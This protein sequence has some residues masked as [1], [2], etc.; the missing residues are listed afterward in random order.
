VCPQ[1][2]AEPGDLRQPA[3]HQGGL[4]VVA[5]T[6]AVGN[7][8]AQ[9]DNVFQGPAQ[10]HPDQVGVGVNPEVIA[11]EEV[12]D[13][14]GRIHV[15]GRGNNRRGHVQTHLLG[16]A[17][18]GEDRVATGEIVSGFAGKN[19]GQAAHGLFFNPLGGVD[20]LHFFVQIRQRRT[21]R[22]AKSMGRHPEQNGLR[23]GNG[24][25]EVGGGPHVFR[26]PDPGQVVF[27]FPV[28]VDPVGQFLPAGPDINRD[29]LLG[30]QHGQRRGPASGADNAGFD[31]H[32]DQH[33]SFACGGL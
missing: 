29:P 21:Q 6:Q 15:T 23:P 4:G 22:L 24:F 17:R 12:L 3:G 20:V 1:G 25:F 27:I 7:A 16:V 11:H 19:L 31:N 30:Q 32:F 14:F 10:F 28:P 9:G 13:V 8:C 26:N 33:H 5:K 18:S 2:S